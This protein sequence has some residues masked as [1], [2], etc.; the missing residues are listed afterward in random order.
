MRYRYASYFLIL[1]IIGGQIL[2]IKIRDFLQS[3]LYELASKRFPEALFLF[4]KTGL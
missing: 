4:Q 3:I 2:Q 1:K